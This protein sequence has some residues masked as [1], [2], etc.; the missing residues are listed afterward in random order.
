MN[1]RMLFLC[2][3]LY[4]SWCLVCLCIIHRDISMKTNMN[5]C[6]MCLFAIQVITI[7]IYIL[8]YNF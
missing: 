2:L 1:M 8:Y 7:T 6:N 3:E 4:H 5:C